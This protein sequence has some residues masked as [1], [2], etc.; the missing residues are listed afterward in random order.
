VLNG[1]GRPIGI[2]ERDV[3]I[4]MIEKK[5]WYLEKPIANFGGYE[6]VRKKSVRGES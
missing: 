2:I 3:L 1:Q 6:E 4:T 5:A